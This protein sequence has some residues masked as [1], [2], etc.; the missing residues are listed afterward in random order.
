MSNGRS[1][2]IVEDSDKKF[3]AVSQCV[4]Q[5]HFGC[6]VVRASTMVEAEK[7]ILTRIWSL[8]VLDV[9]MDIAPSR[10][11]PKVRGQANVGGL[12][13]ARKMFLLDKEAP[14]I[15]VTAFDSFTAPGA[16][17]SRS[18]I[19]GFEEYL[20]SSL[21]ACLRYNVDGWRRSMMEAVQKAIGHE[22]S[23]CT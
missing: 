6:E 11:G 15:I 7:L 1:V 4:K 2:L 17:A 12:A 19:L 13:I 9:S 20:P 5:A 3:E 14:T 10:Y 8:I 16:G 22:N 23:G 18:E 21:V